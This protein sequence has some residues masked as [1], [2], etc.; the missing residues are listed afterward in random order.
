[1][2]LANRRLTRRY[3]WD[4]TRY[5]PLPMDHA[6]FVRVNLAGREPR[7]IVRPGPEYRAVC[8]ELSEALSG[9]RDVDTD[10][11]IV[12]RIY[13]VDDLAPAGAPYR[14]VLPDLVITW[15]E[16]S[17]IRSRGIYRAGH[18]ESRWSGSVTRSLRSGNHRDKGWFIAAGR[19]IEGGS[20]ADSHHITDLVPTVFDW[21]GAGHRDDFQGKPIAVLCGR[22]SA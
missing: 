20:G 8:D 16:R 18:G 21:L 12:E 9:V 1:L 11:P 7:G 10:E 22:R 19:G 3:D 6:G 13:R 5:F 17:A 15:R 14:D 2:Y 4:S